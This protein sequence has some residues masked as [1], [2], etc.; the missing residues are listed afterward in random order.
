M[1]WE[2]QYSCTVDANCCWPDNELAT[3]T[4]ANNRPI[5]V[6]T[7]FVYRTSQEQGFNRALHAK[8]NGRS[9]FKSKFT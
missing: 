3:F 2:K 6:V 5:E 1:V 4:K 9:K 7:I 8:Y